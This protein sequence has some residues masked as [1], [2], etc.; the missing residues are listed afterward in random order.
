MMTKA[1]RAKYMRDRRA[2]FKAE[3]RPYRD[4]ETHRRSW[5]RQYAIRRLLNIPLSA[6][7]VQVEAVLAVA[8]PAIRAQVAAIRAGGPLPESN[9]SRARSLGKRRRHV[10]RCILG[11]PTVHCPQERI[12]AA[13]AEA[14]P[15]TR[16][17]VEAILAGTLPVPSWFDARVAF[18]VTRVVIRSSLRA[19]HGCGRAVLTDLCDVAGQGRLWLCERCTA[20]PP[21]VQRTRK[22]HRDRARSP[23]RLAT[24]ARYEERKHDRQAQT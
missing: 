3:G 15:A 21:A 23:A 13:L 18:K 17:H 24:L 5:Q 20:V 16:E 7:H 6:R 2:R 14:P 11:L 4:A 19:W 22:W 10:A 12:D 8:G 1:E 9:A